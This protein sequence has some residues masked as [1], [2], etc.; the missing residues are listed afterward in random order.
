MSAATS[1]RGSSSGKAALARAAIAGTMSPCIS[2]EYRGVVSDKAPLP[3][4]I[5]S[6][7][8]VT[9]SNDF[10]PSAHS[11]AVSAGWIFW[12]V[13]IPLNLRFPDGLAS[14][15]HRHPALAGGASR[16][17]GVLE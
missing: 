10:C 12:L 16:G 6:T 11:S 5:W 9:A 14:H 15:R 7:A 2:A 8:I 4:R 17:A 3:K 1:L 13:V